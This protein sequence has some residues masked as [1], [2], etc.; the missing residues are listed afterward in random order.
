MPNK[1]FLMLLLLSGC[2]SNVRLDP[3]IVRDIAVTAPVIQPVVLNSVVWQVLTKT[4]LLALSRQN[5]VV[6]GLDDVNYKNLNLNL[7]EIKR[8][9]DEQ[10]TSITMLNTI[11]AQRSATPVP[12]AK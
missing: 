9:L 5:T 3:V 4:E 2:G 10:K 1:I 8:Y 6:F 7:V 11:N 12:P